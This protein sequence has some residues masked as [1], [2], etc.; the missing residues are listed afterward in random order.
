MPFASSSGRKEAS[1]ER[2]T[3]RIQLELNQGSVFRD[4]NNLYNVR[5]LL[6]ESVNGKNYY[7][8]NIQVLR[9]I[10][11]RLLQYIENKNDA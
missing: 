9:D 2:E 5:L 1:G 6:S 11:D 4:L 10:M 7:Y 3:D 8:T